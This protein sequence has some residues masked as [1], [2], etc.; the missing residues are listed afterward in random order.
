MCLSV[1]NRQD[2]TSGNRA[3]ANRPAQGMEDAGASVFSIVYTG[4]RGV[5]YVVY[6]KF[7]KE[8]SIDTIDKSIALRL[9]G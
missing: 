1:G 2:N 8:I 6:A 4:N 3:A 7:H 5:S 9:R